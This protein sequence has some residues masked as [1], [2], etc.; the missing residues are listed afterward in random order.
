[1]FESS[2]CPMALS[3]GFECNFIAQQHALTRTSNHFIG[4]D[5]STTDPAKSSAES[6]L[7]QHLRART[8]PSFLCN[9]TSWLKALLKW[10]LQSDSHNIHAPYRREPA[11]RPAYRR[12]VSPPKLFKVVRPRMSRP[13][14]NGNVH[15]SYLMALGKS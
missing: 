11:F 1:M 14:A 8:T 3:F 10:A 9:L 12:R 4:N 15:L 2:Q 13:H 5:S 7:A 6:F